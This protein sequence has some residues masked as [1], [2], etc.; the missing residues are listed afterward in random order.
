MPSAT[1]GHP[2]DSAGAPDTRADGASVRAG[3]RPVGAVVVAR[4]ADGEAAVPPADGAVGESRGGVPPVGEPPVGLPVGGSQDGLPVGGSQDGRPVDDFQDGLLV[5]GCLVGLR[6][7]GCQADRRVGG[8]LGDLP[9]DACS[10][11]HR[12]ER[13][14]LVGYSV[15]SAES[16]HRAGTNRASTAVFQE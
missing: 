16:R 11:G 3:E 15:G 10:G 6:V 2:G 13:G 8:S 14:E 4:R 9:A 7:D 5:D 12:E 1:N